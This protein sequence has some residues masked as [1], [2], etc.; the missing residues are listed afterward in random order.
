[1]DPIAFFAAAGTRVVAAVLLSTLLV[2]AADGAEGSPDAPVDP[3][4]WTT[5]AQPDGGSAITVQ[6]QPQSLLLKEGEPALFRAVRVR[7]GDPAA[8]RYQWRRNGIDIAGAHKSWLGLDH[9]SLADDGSRYTVVV[10]AGTAATE[11]KPCALRVVSAS[12]VLS[13]ND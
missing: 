3:A 11:S 9:V 1:M 10:S 13:P 4:Q 5:T 7:G 8:L 2:A 6:A 12:T